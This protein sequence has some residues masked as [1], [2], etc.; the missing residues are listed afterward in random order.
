[1]YAVL[2]FR[3]QILDLFDSALACVALVLSASRAKSHVI[4]GKHNSVEERL[5]SVIE[6]TVDEN[7]SFIIRRQARR[8]GHWLVLVKKL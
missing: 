8:F 7:V 2:T 4:Y 6:R 5:I 1:M 3:N